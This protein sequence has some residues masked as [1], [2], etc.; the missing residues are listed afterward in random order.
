MIKALES[1]AILGVS[2]TIEFLNKVMQH[3]NFISGDTHTDFIEKNFPPAKIAGDG[4][5]HKNLALIAAAL[6]ENSL[7]RKDAVEVKKGFAYDVWNAVGNWEIGK[8]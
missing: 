4:Y 5:K 2:T 1:F 3:P 6:A 8:H 7:S